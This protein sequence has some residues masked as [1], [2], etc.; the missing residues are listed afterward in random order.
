MAL[1]H[2]KASFIRETRCLAYKSCGSG[3]G[4]K[5][6]AMVSAFLRSIST[7]DQRNGL[8]SPT[9]ATGETL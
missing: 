5:S 9:S 4:G 3:W 1:K 8:I 6:K 2:I 7:K